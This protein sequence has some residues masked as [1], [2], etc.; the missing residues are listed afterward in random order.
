[1]SKSLLF[2]EFEA[3]TPEAN[4]ISRECDCFVNDFVKKYSQYSTRDIEIILIDS[5]HSTLAEIRLRRAVNQRSEKRMKM[6][7]LH[8]LGKTV[9]RCPHCSKNQE[10][11]IEDH[12]VKGRPD[13]SQSQCIHCYKWFTVIWNGT[14][15]KVSKGKLK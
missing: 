7:D 14:E 4:N 15:F 1:M 5:V 8:K 2:N 6:I 13:N 3:Y 10:G 12:C 11:T 9:M